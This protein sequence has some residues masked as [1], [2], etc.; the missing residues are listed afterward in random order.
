MFTLFSNKKNKQCRAPKL[1]NMEIK[2]VPSV[3]YL[4]VYLDEKLSWKY[5]IDYVAKKLSQLTGVFYH[6]SR[7]IPVEL[8][9]QIYYAYVFP[10]I[11]YGI[12][13]YGSCSKTALNI[14]QVKQSKLLKIVCKRDMRDSSTAL[15]QELKLLNC[16]S[17]H[18]LFTLIFV[19]KQQNKLLPDIFNN[20]FRLVGEVNERITRQQ[21]NLYIPKSK[22]TQGTLTMKRHGAELWND[23][24]EELKCCNSIS[25]FKQNVKLYLLNNGKN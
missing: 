1:N 15:H 8:V 11:K 20:Y 23:L 9:S 3:K 4:G 13:V 18:E 10:Y 24:P 21:N 12:E 14:I 22:L 5:H 6:L 7:F 16:Q 17:I 19:Y 25:L 2:Q